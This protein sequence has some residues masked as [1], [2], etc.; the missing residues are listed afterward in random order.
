MRTTWPVLL[1]LGSVSLIACGED[2][3]APQPVQPTPEDESTPPPTATDDETPEDPPAPDPEATAPTPRPPEEPTEQPDVPAPREG[4]ARLFAVEDED[5]LGFAY[6]EPELEVE[7]ITREL[8]DQDS[9]SYPAIAF[10]DP[11]IG[12]LVNERIEQLASTMQA[13]LSP[14]RSRE[15]R[16][17]S[18]DVRA[19]SR[20]FVSVLCEATEA[21]ERDGRE[22]ELRSLHLAIE[23]GGV[24]EVALAELF[25]PGTD[26]TELARQACLEENDE[27]SREREFCE[28]REHYGV[29]LIVESEGIKAIQTGWF[30]VFGDGGVEIELPYTE[31]ADSLLATGPLAR[32]LDRTDIETREVALTAEQRGAARP[33]EAGALRWAVTPMAASTDLAAAWGSLSAETRGRVQ[34]A[35]NYLVAPDEA[36][37]RAVATELGATAAQVRIPEA[38]VPA[39][40]LVRAAREITL[41]E[42]PVRGAEVTRTLPR[43]TVLVATAPLAE[44]TARYP[45]VVAHAGLVGYVD[46]RS[47]SAS[48]VCAPDLAPFLES[49]PEAAR[50][51]ARTHTLRDAL[52]QGSWGRATYVTSIDGTSHVQLRR[53]EAGC[54]VGDALAGFTRAGAITRLDVA[55]TARRGGDSLVI[56]ASDEPSVT[57][58]RFGAP[59]PV[60]THALAA[61]DTWQTSVRDGEQWYPLVITRAAG[62]PIRVAWGE[63]GPVVSGE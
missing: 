16:Y 28:D 34:R 48:D 8:S 24:R 27:E 44:A 45:Q 54:A 57:I 6:E 4:F 47:L 50:P 38:A 36:T 26:L 23:D 58:H 25:V 41:L 56:T 32:A 20:S 62:D 52:T 21:D 31:L 43:G 7:R 61:T 19:K 11:R 14:G 35:G 55:L 30:D 17:T 40:T 22:I 37:A 53:V 63:T 1:L 29:E 2:A 18:C 33:A 49:L 5:L 59:E 9:V 3:P 60:W 10:P 51:S 39:L 42:Q 46:V 12:A 15:A 13:G